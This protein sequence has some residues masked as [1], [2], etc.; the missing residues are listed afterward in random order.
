MVDLQAAKALLGLLDELPPSCCSSLESSQLPVQLLPQGNRDAL[1][2]LCF[3]AQHFAALGSNQHITAF[4]K[5]CLDASS[6]TDVQELTHFLDLPRHAA[7]YEEAY[8]K[9]MDS[10][11]EFL[12]EAVAQGQLDALRWLR[13]LCHRFCGD[14]S[15]LMGVAAEQGHLR[16]L[17]FLSSFLVQR[18]HKICS[19]PYRLPA[20]AHLSKIRMSLWRRHRR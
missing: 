2:Y 15:G 1:A 19:Q 11:A 16:I 7:W 13:A 20:V 14:T 9:G 12:D 17:K 6:I 18:R 3:A 8:R 10:T 4:D 5:L